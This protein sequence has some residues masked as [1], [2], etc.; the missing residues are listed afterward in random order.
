MARSVNAV[1]SPCRTVFR[2]RLSF[3]R[4]STVRVSA[5][6]KALPRPL[7][8]ERTTL[9]QQYST[10][11]YRVGSAYGWSSIFSFTGLKARDDGGY[12]IAVYGDMGYLNPRAL[13]RLQEL[14]QNGE[15][16]A[17]IHNGTALPSS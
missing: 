10:S 12:K 9:G 2:E 15:I 4:H 17:V 1:F 16:D 3:A 8:A 13:P 6:R 14:A 11:V 7:P 5:A